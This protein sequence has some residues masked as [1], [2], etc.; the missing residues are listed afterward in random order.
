M[1]ENTRD[2]KDE[3]L[4][5]HADAIVMDMTCPLMN[6]PKYWQWWIDGGVTV[7]A[8]TVASN[9]DSRSALAKLSTWRR[10]IREHADRLL[11]VTEVDD[12]RRAKQEKK[13]G[14]VFH[15]Q[16]SLPVDLDPGLVE[17]FAALGLRYMQLAY[18]TQNHVGSGCEEPVDGGLTRFGRRVVRE[19]NRHGVIVDGSHT[20]KRTF[21][22]AM[23]LS[24]RPVIVSHANCKAVA[25]NRRNLDDETIVAVAEQGGLVGL[26]GFPSFVRKGQGHPTLNQLVDHVDHVCQLVGSA[27]AT[28]IAIDYYEGMVGVGSDEDNA[29]VYDDFVARG[30]WDPATYEAPPQYFPE[31]LEDPRKFPNLTS[32]LLERGYSRA[33]VLSIL[34]GNWIRVLESRSA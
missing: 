16:N 21:L 2:H 24:E 14:I 10:W 9:D 5:L 8:P 28:G 19:M 32:K 7:A 30:I 26:V 20:G 31:G 25:D 33:D 27:R 6:L 12:V 34:G 17:V 4:R 11:H 23:E 18:N 22:D 15:F 29:R 1:V 13:L 3:A